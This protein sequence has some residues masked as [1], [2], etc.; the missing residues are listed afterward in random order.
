[1]TKFGKAFRT[2]SFV[3]SAIPFATA[4]SQGRETGAAQIASLTPS[5][6]NQGSSTLDLTVRGSG[7]NSKSQIRVNGEHRQTTFISSTDLRTSLLTADVALVRQSKVSVFTP[8]VGSTRDLILTVNA[9]VP[10]D[11]EAPKFISTPTNLT[12]PATSPEGANVAL[13][14]PLATDNSGT[15]KVSSVPQSGIGMVFPVGTTT[16]I[17]TAEDPSG[18]KTTITSTIVVT[19]QPPPPTMSIGGLEPAS[20]FPGAVGSFTLGVRGA[21][22]TNGM[23][24]RWNGGARSTTFLAS[25][26]LTIIVSSRDLV[27]PG[28]TSVT[29]FDP[30]TGSETPVALFHIDASRSGVPRIS[31]LGRNTGVAGASFQ[32]SVNGEGF[33]FG[34]VVRINGVDVPANGVSVNI[35]RIMGVT[36]PAAMTPS[37]GVYQITVF[38]PG[39]NGGESNAVPLTLTAQ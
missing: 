29:V 2:M 21:A 32:T 22:F 17:Y 23:V 35:G 3:I 31:S 24:V 38:N 18:N 10:S 14:L 9:A 26:I 34:S 11:T 25:S 27:S 8:G 15:V 7:F 12:I 20:A 13:V 5:T 33:V 30:A 6:I 1:V 39:P 16:V 28:T 4:V 19:P 37:A 36:I